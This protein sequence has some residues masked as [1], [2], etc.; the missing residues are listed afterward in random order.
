MEEM[1]FKLETCLQ[2]KGSEVENTAYKNRTVASPSWE[3]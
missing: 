3:T 1:S 2:W